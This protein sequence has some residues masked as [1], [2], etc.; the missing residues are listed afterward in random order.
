MNLKLINIFLSSQSL[1]IKFWKFIDNLI[2]F[3]FSNF[4]II[5]TEKLVNETLSLN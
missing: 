2:F 5:G 4:L 1:T 3:I